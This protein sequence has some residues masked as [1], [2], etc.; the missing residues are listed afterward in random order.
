MKCNEVSPQPLS[1]KFS[2]SQ[3]FITFL[4]GNSSVCFSRRNKE[5]PRM[6][7]TFHN[8]NVTTAP[9]GPA[10]YKWG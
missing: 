9:E 5:S 2:V 6:A 10:I 4:Y 1:A 3:L 7:T 8:D